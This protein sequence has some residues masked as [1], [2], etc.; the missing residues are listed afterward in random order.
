MKRENEKKLFDI[1]LVNY[2]FPRRVP[3][4]GRADRAL[5]L[6]SAF[7]FAVSAVVCSLHQTR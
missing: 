3:R 1:V 6:S 7:L 2:F 4:A 5:S